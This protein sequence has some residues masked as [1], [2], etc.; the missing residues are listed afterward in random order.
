[1]LVDTGKRNKSMSNK[2]LFILSIICL[3]SGSMVLDFSYPY[4]SVTG[5]SL[6][7]ISFIAGIGAITNYV[8]R[9]E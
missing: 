7:L 4:A 3:L 1:M 9:N 8:T 6:L 2:S 5:M